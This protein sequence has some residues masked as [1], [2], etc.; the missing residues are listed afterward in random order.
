RGVER[1]L[2]PMLPLPQRRLGAGAFDRVPRALRDIAYER[3]LGGRPVAWGRVIGAEGCQEPPVLDERRADEGRNL[4][5]FHPDALGFR[6]PRIR[7]NVVD[8][9]RLA[10]PVRLAQRRAK[11]PRWSVADKRRDAA[12]VLAA[13]DVAVVLHFGV[14]D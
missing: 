4:S 5:A 1:E 14:A 13:N 10:A 3:D 6:E 12:R 8:H 11:A 7:R 9:D 2:Q